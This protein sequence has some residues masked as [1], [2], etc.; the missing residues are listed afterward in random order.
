MSDLYGDEGFLPVTS[1]TSADCPQRSQALPLLR[2]GSLPLVPR[3]ASRAGG[4]SAFVD[5]PSDAAAPLILDFR[6]LPGT[7]CYCDPASEQ[8]IRD[9]V[10]HSYPDSEEEVRSSG[11]GM[12]FSPHG[13]AQPC[14]RGGPTTQEWGGRSERRERRGLEVIPSEQTADRYVNWIDTGDYHY[15]SA[16]TIEDWVRRSGVRPLLILL[17]N[18]PDMQTTAFG[19]DILSCGGWVRTVV[20]KDL[21]TGVLAIGTDPEL[22]SEAEDLAGRGVRIIREKDNVA[23][24]LGAIEEGAPVWISLDLDVLDRSIFATDWNQGSMDLK[25]LQ[26]ILEALAAHCSICSMDICGGLTIAKGA[27]ASELAANASLRV[28]L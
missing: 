14:K 18:H 9:A 28:N 4:Q 1:S 8:L 5:S 2:R 7:N 21:V 26:D 15:L 16:I 17:D 13:H 10:L 11:E 6:D 12:I 27:T 22:D 23:A 3:A 20:E 24:L 25:E 19:G